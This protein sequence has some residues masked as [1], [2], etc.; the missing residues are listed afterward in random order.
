MAFVEVAGSARRTGV[1][2]DGALVTEI[3]K[4]G[5][6]PGASARNRTLSDLPLS[7]RLPSHGQSGST[8][9][10]EGSTSAFG[11]A[12]SWLQNCTSVRQPAP[13]TSHLR[14][15]GGDGFE[16]PTPAL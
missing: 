10:W 8:H 16:P 14:A 7:K 3:P 9:G 13:A 2:G 6:T 11:P 12:K 4:G 5:S 1:D 15:V